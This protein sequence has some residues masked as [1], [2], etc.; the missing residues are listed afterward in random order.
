[1]NKELNLR[2]E[3]LLQKSQI[4][5]KAKR[6]MPLKLDHQAFLLINK[7]FNSQS[8]KLKNKIDLN[9]S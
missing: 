9:A 1:M 7:L 6:Q 4:S 3:K 5:V 8:L 2:N